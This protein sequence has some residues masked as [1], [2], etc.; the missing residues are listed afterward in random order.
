MHKSLGKNEQSND[1]TLGIII[2]VDSIASKQFF[3]D[4]T[5]S[6]VCT[7]PSS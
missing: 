3:H 5:W 2:S 4:G 7:A 1:I 6:S